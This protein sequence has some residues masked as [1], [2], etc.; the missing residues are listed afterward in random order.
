MNSNLTI[1]E[2]A[3]T[4]PDAKK[5]FKEGKYLYVI[6]GEANYRKVKGIKGEIRSTFKTIK[7]FPDGFCIE[8]NYAYRIGDEPKELTLSQFVELIEPIFKAYKEKEKLNPEEK[9]AYESLSNLLG[10]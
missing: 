9:I 7:V 3:K 4:Y 5:A 8:T 10:F 1:V 2:A 6:I